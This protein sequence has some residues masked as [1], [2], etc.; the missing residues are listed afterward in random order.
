MLKA[1]AAIIDVADV[2]GKVFS[3][4]ALDIDNRLPDSIRSYANSIGGMSI[5]GQVASSQVSAG[6]GNFA[7]Q[8]AAAPS[9]PNLQAINLTVQTVVDDHAR[10]ME[11]RIG[12]APQGDYKTGPYGKK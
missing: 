10:K 8:A 12:L 7:P 6:G 2:V 4:G 9:S 3:F 11:Q 1:V 5:G